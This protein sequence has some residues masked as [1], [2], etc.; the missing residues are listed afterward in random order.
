M[1]VV[2]CLLVVVLCVDC[3]LLCVFCVLIWIPL[4]RTSSFGLCN[5]GLP[6]HSVCFGHR[7][8]GH[9]CFGP[10]A[11]AVQKI[12]FFVPLPTLLLFFVFPIPRSFVELRWFLCVSITVKSSQNIWDI[13]TSCEARAAHRIGREKKRDIFAPHPDRSTHSSVFSAKLGQKF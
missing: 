13:R 2:G 10:F 12:V 11:R 9:L 7:C 4:P 1:S 5:P 3:G 6:P 8:P